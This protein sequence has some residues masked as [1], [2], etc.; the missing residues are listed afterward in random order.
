MEGNHAEE[1]PVITDDTQCYICRDLPEDPQ[2]IISCG[3][4]FCGGCIMTNAQRQE[5]EGLDVD[6]PNPH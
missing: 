5:A 3:H 2:Q 4:I 1:D 6:I